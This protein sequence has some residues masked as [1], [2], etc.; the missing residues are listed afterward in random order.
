MT[1]FRI[2]TV[3]TGNICR[4]PMAEAMLRH[5]L[6]GL[7]DYQVTSAGTRAVV[8]AGMTLES[9][10]VLEGL[11]LEDDPPHVARQLTEAML[12]QADLILA[13]TRSH[14]REAVQLD[15][16]ATGR[17]FTLRQFGCV[18]GQIGPDDLAAAA[19]RLAAR[20]RAVGQPPNLH[21]G[22]VATAAV[23]AASGTFPVSDPAEF[24]VED[25]YGQPLA[26]YAATA[27]RI[28]PAVEAT[29]DFLAATALAGCP[30]AA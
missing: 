4:S 26:V 28:L 2:I 24:D 8:G 17:A 6:T 22:R 5:Y 7:D 9:R 15:P 27:V 16:S 1:A 12:R 29:A 18:A 10:A 25:P 3:C 30:T 11:G 19:R 23:A 13:L 14:R 21:P 20:Q